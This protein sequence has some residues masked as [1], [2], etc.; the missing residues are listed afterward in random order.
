M[1]T[2]FGCLFL[3]WLAPPPAVIRKNE[4]DR[5]RPRT[6]QRIVPMWFLRCYADA[7]GGENNLCSVTVRSRRPC[8]NPKRTV[9]ANKGTPWDPAYL[10]KYQYTAFNTPPISHMAL[11]D[12]LSQATLNYVTGAG[13]LRQNGTQTRAEGDVTFY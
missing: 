10:I 8:R 9:M 1:T 13:R 3:P 4:I 5:R 2:L 12:R 7:M 6:P 11:P